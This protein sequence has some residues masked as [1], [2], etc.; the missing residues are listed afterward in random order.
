MPALA[1]TDHGVMYGS[2]D[3]YSKCRAAGV[4]PIL[5]VEAYVAPRGR[6]MKEPKCSLYARNPDGEASSAIRRISLRLST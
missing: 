2:A 4:K 3:F 6:N 1:L 5:G